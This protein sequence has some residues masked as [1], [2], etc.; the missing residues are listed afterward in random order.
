MA[1]PLHDFRFALRRWRHHP[2]FTTVALLSLALGIGANTSIFSLMD[3]LMLRQLPVREPDRLTLLGP[4]RMSGTLSGF[5]SAEADLFSLP[6]LDRVRQQ[7]QVFSDVAGM[8]SMRAD[9]HGRFPGDN[10]EPEPLKIRLVSGNYFALLG[11]GPAA[12][13]LLTMEDDRKPGA[14]P[15]VVMSHAF[16]QRRFSRDANVIGRAVTFNG[17]SFNIIGVAAR[18][19]SGTVVDESP[20]LWI[21]LSMQAEV[22]PWLTDPRGNLMQTL[23]LIGRLKPGIS[24]AAAQTN[25]NV[26]YQQWMHDVAGA[27]PSPQRLQ[28][29]RKARIQLYSAAYGTSDLRLQFSDPLKILM[30][31]VGLVLLIAC[32]NI[33]NLLLAQATGRQREIAVRLAL[34][35]DRRRLM[36]QLLSESL[37]LAFVGGALGVLIAWW[38]GQLMLALVQSGPDRLPLQVG[39]NTNV[40]L[41]TFGLSLATGLFF[42]LAPALR[43]TQVDVGPSL[44]EGK[45]TARSQSR[46]RFGQALVAG[47]VALALFLMIGAGLFVRT[48]EKL[49][50]TNTGFE[51]SRTVL[52]QLDSDASNAKGPA[53][54]ALRRRVEDRIRALPGVKAVSYSMLNFNEGQWFTLLWPDTVQHLE[55]TALRVDGNRIGPEYFSALGVP[56]AMG[57]SFGPQDTPQSAKVAMVNEALAKKMYPGQ[58]PIGRR[59]VR[60]LEEPVDYEIVGIA[61]DAKYLSV[62]EKARPMFFVDTDQEKIPD[63]YN[64]LVVR[65]EGRAEAFMTQIRAAIRSEDPNLALWDITTLGEAVERSLSR[66]KLLAKLAGFFGALALLLASIGLYGVMAYS[67]SRRTNEIGIR[68]ALGAQPGNVLGMVLRE[69]VAVVAIGFG[70][71]IPAALACGRYVASQLYG[72]EPNDAPT[73]AASAAILL[74]VALAASILPARRAALLDPL[75]ALR[76]E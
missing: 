63:A 8:E 21:P 10:N 16:W 41:F 61:K 39:P 7:N 71:G 34:G 30:V 29:M 43:M 4:G 3:A 58:S 20:D 50:Q 55:S 12:G 23:W 49:E 69:S 19:F 51:R 45:G 36:S 27:T 59:L 72:V 6:F 60:G 38:G 35:A 32:V 66:E 28:D 40:L 57:R 22:Q 53:L 67:V 18:E 15:V 2:G 70:A 54:V 31:L 9:V 42:G 46:S 33:A 37:F 13:R 17:A 25:A 11:V 52:L 26:V 74:V 75:A 14:N 1:N 47:Q 64:D 62:R 24:R 5:P 65:V 48:L 76:E 44:K 73:I 56:I 68:M